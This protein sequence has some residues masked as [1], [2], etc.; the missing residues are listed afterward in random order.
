VAPCPSSEDYKI[1][2]LM[3]ETWAHARHKDSLSIPPG[4]ISARYMGARYE[5][6]WKGRVLA[7]GGNCRT[8]ARTHTRTHARRQPC[9]HLI[10]PRPE[11]LFREPRL[12]WPREG[13]RRDGGTTEERRLALIM[14][15]SIVRDHS[16]YESKERVRGMRENL[17]GALCGSGH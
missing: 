3:Q 13:R 16:A 4:T 17:F 5:A 1:S 6:P 7:P 14:P 8:P 10:P 12:P 11:A 9:L 15:T 2:A